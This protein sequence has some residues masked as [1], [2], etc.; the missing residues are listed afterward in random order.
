[1]LVWGVK[2]KKKLFV[3]VCTFVLTLVV[4]SFVTAQSQAFANKTNEDVKQQAEKIYEN[5]DASEKVCQT[6]M[7][8]AHQW[9]GVDA[10][11]VTPD[12]AEV[13][14]K[15]HYGGF[16]L[17]GENTSTAKNTLSFVTDLQRNT[18]NS[19][20]LPLIMAPDQEGGAV[21]RLYAGT[22][23]CGNMA[24]GATQN[25]QVAGNS[26]AIVGRELKAFGITGNLAPCVDV[27]TNAGNPII[28]LRSFGDDKDQVKY[29][30]S[31][32][33]KQCDSNGTLACAKHFPGHGDVATDS[34]IG[35]PAND[36]NEQE[37]LS[38]DIVPFKQCI[39]DGL[40]MIMTAHIQYKN[41][42]A[43]MLT[44]DKTDASGQPLE[45]IVPPATL[46]K[47]IMTNILREKLNYNGIAC[48]DALTMQGVSKFFTFPT[49]V[50]LALN[51][52]N[53]MCA[54]PIPAENAEDYISQTEAIIARVN[55]WAAE[56]AANAARLK[57]AVLRVIETKIKTGIINYNPND[58]TIEKANQILRNPQ[59]LATEYLDTAKSITLTKNNNDVLP[60][61]LNE[62]SKVLYL[63]QNSTSTTNKNRTSAS[64]FAIAWNRLKANKLIP[65][66]LEPVIYTFDNTT[67]IN[68]MKG[69]ID[70]ADYVITDS[71][72][73]A[74]ELMGYLSWQTK[75]PNDIVNYAHEK[76]K[77]TVVL[78]VRL[79]YDAQLYDNA[80]A[81]LCTYNYTGS[82]P[83]Y[84]TVLANGATTTDDACGPN[85][86]EGIEAI[87]GNISPTGKL[88]VSVPEFNFNKDNPGYNNKIIYP[89]G[90]GLTYKTGQVFNLDNTNISLEY[91][92]VE[93]DGTEKCPKVTIVTN[94]GAQISY[95]SASQ[96][97]GAGKYFSIPMA[98]E[99]KTFVT[100][101]DFDVDYSDNVEPGQASLT[102]TGKGAIVG[103]KTINYKINPVTDVPQTGD[104]IFIIV[105][106]I[107]A[108]ILACGVTIGIY[109][110]RKNKRKN[111]I[112]INSKHSK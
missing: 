82:S 92:E 85:L 87:F 76:G 41:I 4:V 10:T 33:M 3:A 94:D 13:F 9:N 86:I 57:E 44:P 17:F 38:S 16:V 26:G 112:K 61:K 62:N 95:A 101:Q 111:N 12:M 71:G 79:P 40:Q 110:W 81:I 35:L 100:G 15:Y 98:R 20:G 39:D 65:D 102:I 64:S 56:D 50:V 6:L 24:T 78:S 31:A 2:M 11:E 108:I 106:I 46:S 29:L 75:T 96:N 89:N 53:D 105:L 43:S 70:T 88:P 52:G 49:S 1:M 90:Y 14:Q 104:K 66:S 84:K 73:S 34:H 7:V 83:D 68:Q 48:T 99:S 58:Y 22:S 109:N 37:L 25:T 63:T 45:P 77:K 42:D 32:F 51:A 69:M 18:I 23:L 21:F 80:D 19:G 60:I 74:N 55:S 91:N 72:V 28:G 54:E 47:Y 93:A 8:H 36:K 5:M 67:I 107:L 103:S 59:T 27:N 97:N 30:G